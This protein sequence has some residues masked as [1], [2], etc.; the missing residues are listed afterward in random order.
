AKLRKASLQ[1]FSGSRSEHDKRSGGKGSVHHDPAVLRVAPGVENA[2][3]AD[4]P[5]LSIHER[6]VLVCFSP[7]CN[8]AVRNSAVGVSSPHGPI[9]VRT[10]ALGPASRR[11]SDRSSRLR[12]NSR[13][14]P[15]NVAGGVISGN[16]EGVAG[17]SG[18]AQSLIVRCSRNADL[19]AVSVH[20]VARDTD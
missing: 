9:T 20:P 10:N 15:G 16:S 3:G 8:E 12:R 18:Q 7:G 4:N 1:N 11:A 17:G 6:H 14:L 13:C 5:N 2:V 19:I